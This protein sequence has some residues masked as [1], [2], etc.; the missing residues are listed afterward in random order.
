VRPLDEARSYKLLMDHGYKIDDLVE[1]LH[2]SKS[3]IYGRMKLLELPEE[4]M[5]AVETGALPASHA[6][7]LLKVDDRAA[8]AKL[9]KEM[10][11][12]RTDTYDG[13][14]LTISFRDAKV[15]VSEEERKLKEAK[16]W[17]EATAKYR[18][19]G[20]KVLSRA[21][22]SRVI[23]YGSLKPDYVA[24]ND[25]CEAD[26][27]GRT[28]KA[29]MSK[30]GE[31]RQMIVAHNAWSS[32]KVRLVFARKT[33]EK[34]LSEGGL[35]TAPK[36]KLSPAEQRRLEEEKAKAERAAMEARDNEVIAQIVAAAEAREPNAEVLRFMANVIGQDRGWGRA[37]M[38]ERREPG[39]DHTAN[40]DSL[41][42]AYDELVKKSDGKRLRGILMELLL[43]R[44]GG[45]DDD[46][47]KLAAALF[48]VKVQTPGKGR[49]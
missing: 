20:C 46:R 18:E 10:L 42:K 1:K 47:L 29:L 21:Q 15:M 5:T 48:N 6:E 43:C 12:P 35:I 11:A 28:W 17:E 41:N 34:L 16:E 25:K 13:S 4:A 45:V 22:S 23:N 9:A 36:A 39:I 49:K 33:A 27:Q 19:D 3:S 37:R 40:W 26:P 31:D 30:L 38:L 44:H 8:Q 7:L 32:E 24:A 2:R 14:P